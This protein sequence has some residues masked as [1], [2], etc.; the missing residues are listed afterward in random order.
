MFTTDEKVELGFLADDLRD[1]LI[2]HRHLAQQCVEIKNELP[3]MP[4]VFDVLSDVLRVH[5]QQIRELQEWIEAHSVTPDATQI[6]ERPLEKASFKAA[7]ALRIPGAISDLIS[8]EN[9]LIMEYVRGINSFTKV[10]GLEALLSTHEYHLRQAVSKL[11]DLL[12]EQSAGVETG[13]R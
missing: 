6:R 13:I 1:F 12:T 10:E 7:Q 4:R 9:A 11:S 3:D 2:R 8:W 5:V